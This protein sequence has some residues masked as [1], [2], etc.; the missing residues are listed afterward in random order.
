MRE[1][2]CWLIV[3]LGLFFMFVTFGTGI[4]NDAWFLLNHGRFVEQNGFPHVEPFTI[5][6]DFHFVMQQW[7]F[8][9]GLWKVYSLFGDAGLIGFAY[10]AGMIILLIYYKALQMVSE[11][12]TRVST[13]MAVIV[14]CLIFL[15]FVRQ[16]P[17]VASTAIF[18]LEIY[19]LEKYYDRLK[20]PCYIYALFFL[21]SVLLINVHAAMWPLFM[22]F[23]IPY[24]IETLAIG[25]YSWYSCTFSW[26]C[27]TVILLIAIS[28]AA[29]FFNPY[30]TENMAYTIHSYGYKEIN[31]AV[32]EMQPLALKGP[33]PSIGIII[34]FCFTAIYARH[35]LP[36][37]YLLLALGTG[38][39]AASSIRSLFLFLVIGTLPLA[40]ILKYWQ[41]TDHMS[42]ISWKQFYLQGG[43]MTAV[44]GILLFKI[45]RLHMMTVRWPLLIFLVMIFGGI[46]AHCIY[47]A[48]RDMDNMV[49]SKIKKRFYSSLLVLYLSCICS[50][51]QF[52]DLAVSKGQAKSIDVLLTDSP[53]SEINLWTNYN[54]GNYPEF[55]GIRCYMDT[56]AEIFLL[57]INHKKNVMYEYEK[58]LTG[59]L[60][61]REFVSRY[62]FT[63]FLTRGNDI[64]YTYLASDSD[65]ELIWDS[66]TD[67]ETCG[68]DVPKYEW[69]RIYKYRPNCYDEAND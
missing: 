26:C 40:Y 6:N 4:D 60:D 14:G 37:R 38:Y 44:A 58:L 39:M 5:H 59:E 41:P 32:T 47:M 45:M 42:G 9:F 52:D 11:G 1:I 65:Y 31:T 23:M 49:S 62:H 30:G 64:L 66:Q 29:G 28:I 25:K 7:L 43:L 50:G 34:L 57:T 61:Y 20:P 22:V 21:L 48:Y 27:K 54:D 8:A 63:H 69:I 33:M 56:R 19:S 15:L 10:I 24:L 53:A 2:H 46:A 3:F 68:E 35:K 16:R 18:L 55:C 51:F 17:Q 12:N 13:E 67:P 36:L